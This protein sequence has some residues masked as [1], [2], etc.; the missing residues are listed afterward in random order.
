MIPPLFWTL[1]TVVCAYAFWR[2]RS[3]E[4]IAASVCLGA[5]L[6]TKFLISPMQ[7]RY[8][9]IETGL[10]AIDML[11]FAGFLFIALRSQRFWP[12]WIAGLQLT[13]SMSHL[14]KAI[15]YDLMP[16]AYAAAAAFWSYPI[17]IILAV[18]TWRTD[19]RN[20]ARRR[21]ATP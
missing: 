17:L 2:G 6:A 20:A 11:V 3:D 4:R 16:S 19:R 18:G 1:L 7:Y 8:Q 13:N 9:N 12:L 15:D 5:S 14:L 10:V 21:F